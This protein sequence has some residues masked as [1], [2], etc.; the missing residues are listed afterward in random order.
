LDI[1]TPKGQETLKQ[2]SEAISL[3]LNN[4][5]GF[6]FVHTPKDM[7]ADIDGFVV[8]NGVIFSGVEVKCRTMTLHELHRSFSSKWLIT[9]DKI[10]RGIALCTKLGVDFRGFLYLVPDQT[11]LIVKIWD[12]KKGLVCDMDVEETKTQATVNGGT[13]IRLNAYIDIRDAA[14]IREDNQ[15]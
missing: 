1:L 5:A 10:D 2:E 11:L 3:F 6:E 13:A 14:V 4:Y 15:L 8:K 9:Y 12:H 7:P